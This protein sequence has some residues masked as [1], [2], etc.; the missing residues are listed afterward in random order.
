MHCLTPSLVDRGNQH[1]ERKSCFCCH[2]ACTI[3]HWAPG[4]LAVHGWAWSIQICESARQLRI[5]SAYC[6]GIWG[7]KR[8]SLLLY[9]LTCFFAPMWLLVATGDYSRSACWG[10]IAALWLLASG[11]ACVEAVEVHAHWAI[12]LSVIHVFIIPSLLIYTYK[13]G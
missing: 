13:S 7:S 9:D 8:V 4:N 6:L 1:G 12:L 2:N 10:V 11:G 3:R 5:I